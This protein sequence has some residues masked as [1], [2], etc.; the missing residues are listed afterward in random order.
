[1]S[2]RIAEAALALC[3][4][5][6]VLTAGTDGFVGM[7]R[8]PLDQ[9]G[10]IIPVKAAFFYTSD[11]YAPRPY[12]GGQKIYER[13]QLEVRIRSARDDYSGGTQLARQIYEALEIGEFD[14]SAYSDIDFTQCVALSSKAGYVG[15]LDKDRWHQWRIVFLVQYERTRS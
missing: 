12:I 8:P 9:D 11:G 15:Q 6:G 3:E 7:M 4:T 5:Q 10:A 1:M 13:D 2:D 14:F